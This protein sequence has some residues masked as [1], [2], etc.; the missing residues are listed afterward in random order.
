MSLATVLPSLLAALQSNP[1]A[2][3][4][5]PVR[6]AVIILVDGFAA[7]ELKARIG[8]A[9]TLGSA[10]TR[11]SVIESGFP[12]TTA[13]AVTTLTTG[14]TPGIHGMVGYRIRDDAGRMTNQLQGWDDVMQP[15]TW[16]RAST[17][18]ER[19]EREGVASS[20]V[21]DG[22]YTNSGFTHAVL[23]GARPVAASS[24]TD[25]LNVA[26]QLAAEPG[27]GLTYVYVSEL[28]H[29]GHHD[30]LSSAAWI[31][32]LEEIDSAV[33]GFLTK[34]P[35][36]VGVVITAD[37]G[38]VDIPESSHVFYDTAALLD[39]VDAVGGEPR[40]L[41]LY[42]A[43]GSVPDQVAARWRN[44]EGERAWVA[45]RD[46]AFRAGWFGSVVDEE[47]RHRVGDVLVGARKRVA[48][49]DS[50]DPDRIGR[51]MIGQHGSLTPEEVRVPL[52]RF[53]AFG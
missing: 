38:M 36:D 28:D 43:P 40:F 12:T 9:R 39:G 30:G 42:T 13:A 16:Q 21:L 31:Q 27:P 25:R 29:A 52:L 44:T 18:F 47:V 46:E 26:A 10:L 37:H 24:V 32:V 8:H 51:N 3:S 4:L 49:Y 6:H 20:A 11:S 45:T 50:R 15:E 7:S 35:S 2:L 5:P 53:G 22:T 19:A 41:H 1:N 17:V 34:I 23:R 33:R 14:V 48:Y